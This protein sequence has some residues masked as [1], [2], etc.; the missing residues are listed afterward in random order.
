MTNK[1]WDSRICLHVHHALT[2]GATT[3]LVRTVDTDVVV[4]LLGVYHDL[5][6]HHPAMQLWVGFGTGKNF[7]Y[8]HINSIGHE[9]GQ[10]KSRA[11][12]F[13]H[14]FSGCD[15]TSQFSGKAKKSTWNTWKSYPAG[16]EGFIITPRTAFVQHEILSPA[17][18][19]IEQFTCTMYD[20]TTSCVKVNDCRQELFPIRVKQMEKFPPT[21]NALLQHTNRSM[22]ASGQYLERIAEAH[23]WCPKS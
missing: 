17:F 19:I 16:T 23:H 3:I 15:C 2:E 5:E 14:A 13:W 18:Q 7:R 8:Y 22:P 4:I 20:S 10:N 21:Q 11:L 6:P 9:L 12:P 1:R